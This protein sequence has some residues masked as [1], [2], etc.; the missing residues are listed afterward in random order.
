MAR[1]AEWRF[2]ALFDRHSVPIPIRIKDLGLPD[3]VASAIRETSAA[4]QVERRG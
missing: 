4:E 3:Q 2:L 1:F